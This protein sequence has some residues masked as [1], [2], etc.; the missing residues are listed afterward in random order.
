MLYRNLGYLLCLL[1]A[2]VGHGQV[3]EHWTARQPPAWQIGIA[4]A[5]API[6]LMGLGE[7][8]VEE[9]SG[10]RGI[11]AGLVTAAAGAVLHLLLDLSCGLL[12]LWRPREWIAGV[13]GGLVGG[14]VAARVLWRTVRGLRTREAQTAAR[15]L[16]ATPLPEGDGAVARLRRELALFG[17]D[18]IAVTLVGL[19]FVG[20][21]LWA[22]IARP[23][24]GASRLGAALF[25]AGCAVVGVW[26]GLER[27]AA[28]LGRPSIR[29]APAWLARRLVRCFVAREGLVLFDRG[30]MT[31]VPWAALEEVTLASVAHN[32][33][34][35]VR[36]TEE[37][38]R[39]L[40]RR[41]PSP[42][43]RERWRRRQARGL[44]WT[45]ALYGADLFVP[46]V[47]CADGPGVLHRVL[48]EALAD[49][50]LRERWPTAQELFL[51]RFG[52]L[53]EE[54]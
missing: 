41:R 18:A 23:G 14:L 13:L 29:L 49:P 52:D 7:A 50:A 34:L 24:Q 9:C 8:L 15:L 42:A 46:G 10:A 51:Q 3:I 30:G 5:M 48:G 6:V 11:R 43:H 28:L 20:L 17:G 39:R 31:L 1:F 36:L 2:A 26:M 53:P 45:R 38:V 47:V 35:L 54:E 25:F 4:L 19:G 27:R 12:V 21:A 37:E 32:F 44:A 33:S 40:W 22:F 16:V